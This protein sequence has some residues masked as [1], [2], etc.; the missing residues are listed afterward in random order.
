MR[1][2]LL[3]FVSLAVKALTGATATH[4]RVLRSYSFLSCL[5]SLDDMVVSQEPFSVS[6][7]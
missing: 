6:L 3:P 2:R 5:P 1:L 7:S 4:T